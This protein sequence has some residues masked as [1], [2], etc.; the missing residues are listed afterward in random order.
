MEETLYTDLIA[1]Y[2]SGN[3]EA[4]EREQLWAWVEAD[5]AN[6]TFFDEM[7]QLWG[8]SADTKRENFATDTQVAWSKV[9][10]RL[11]GNAIN[12][13]IVT[14]QPQSSKKIVPL[15]IKR[16]WWAAA[17]VLLLAMAASIWMYVQPFENQ[18]IVYETSENERR[19][20]TLP[21]SSKIWL[22]ENTR[23][24]FDKNFE[25]RI[26]QLEGE[27]FFN[28]TD[29]DGK[30]FMIR[31]GEATTTVWGTTFN[32]R[33]Y[34]TEKNV[35]VTVETGEVALSKTKNANKTVLLKA[36]KSGVFDKKTEEVKL[37]EEEIENADAWKTQQLEFDE[38]PMSEVVQTM[39][40]Y[41]GVTIK[42]E[43]P[44]ILSC[45]LNLAKDSPNLQQMIKTIEFS[46]PVQIEKQDSIY[47][48]RGKGCN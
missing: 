16:G 34:P 21:D 22:N 19:L 23:L 36:G 24:S 35:E 1:S 17:A 31:S 48:I 26:V 37:V 44:A 2:L 10:S 6:R 13:P 11:F 32:V 5:A 33:A 20:Y 28:V 27:A 41:Y 15:S 42:V 38:T 47:I 14:L 39:E 29:L 46:L 4:A 8:M 30:Q 45:P 40:R 3:I 18:T 12:T 9:E 25:Q 43:N 7:V